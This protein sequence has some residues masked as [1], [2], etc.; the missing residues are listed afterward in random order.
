M[1]Y[2]AKAEID[3]PDLTGWSRQEAGPISTLDCSYGFY[4]S[5]VQSIIHCY[6]IGGIIRLYINRTQGTSYNSFR[7]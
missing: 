4:A 5:L 1:I 6:L 3:V 2:I 7:L